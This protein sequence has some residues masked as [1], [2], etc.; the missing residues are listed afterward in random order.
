MIHVF[1]SRW[2][3]KYPIEYVNKLYSMLRRYMPCDFTLYCQTDD[4][5]GLNGKV[6]QLPFL[7]DLPESTP[8]EMMAS[9]D[10]RYGLPRLWDRPKLNYFKPNAWGISGTKMAF[11]IDIIIHNNMKPVVELFDDKPITARSWWHNREHEQRPDWAYRRGAHNNGGFYMWTDD[12]CVDIWEDCLKNAER[13]YYLFTGGS[14]NFI[15]QRHISLFQFLPPTMFYSFNRG[16]EW[17]HDLSK[18]KIRK[19]KIMCVF[20]TDPG[21]ATNFEIHD[22][23]KVYPEVDALWK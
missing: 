15:S 1:C 16:C 23:I 6:I 7:T 8:E 17:P 18:H 21:N 14:D 22:A 20:N 12:M 2:G 11:D 13:I 3:D 9:K 4:T 19:E 5:D 10:Y